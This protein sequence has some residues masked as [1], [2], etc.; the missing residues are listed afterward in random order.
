[1][2]HVVSYISMVTLN[3]TLYSYSH[4]IDAWKQ[5]SWQRHRRRLQV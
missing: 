3:A 5:L 4:P 1:M 2:R